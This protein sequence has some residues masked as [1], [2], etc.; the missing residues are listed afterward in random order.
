MQI[1]REPTEEPIP[2]E[3][4]VAPHIKVNK[5]KILLTR[6]E[7]KMRFF[8]Y[9]ASALRFRTHCSLVHYY[10]FYC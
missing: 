10:E 9:R 2:G 7:G 5:I 1:R 4:H 8:V 3:E 6:V